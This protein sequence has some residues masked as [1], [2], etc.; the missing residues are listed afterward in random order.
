MSFVVYLTI[1]MSMEPMPTYGFLLKFSSMDACQSHIKEV[2]KR[3]KLT[4]DQAERMQCMPVITG[5]VPV[6]T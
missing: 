2:V 4:K 6:Y 1:L 3:N 5:P